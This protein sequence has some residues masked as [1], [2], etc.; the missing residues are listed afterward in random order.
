MLKRHLVLLLLLFP[1]AAACPRGVSDL[2]DTLSGKVI[3]I[4]DGDTL[5]I[6]YNNKK[7][8]IRLAH[9]DCP[10]KKQP[11][12]QAAKQFISGKCFGQTVT[13]QHRNE[14]DRSKRLIGEVISASGENLNKALVKAGLAWHFKKYSTDQV[15]AALEQA[16]RQQRIGLW[17]EP[18]PVAPWEWRK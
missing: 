9:I 3:N 17:S 4:K 12:G 10:E 15:Y 11:Y 16:A 1:V 7:L 13:I 5:D 14:Y 2:A 18:N 8:T 6:L